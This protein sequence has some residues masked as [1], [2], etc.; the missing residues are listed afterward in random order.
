MKHNASL[1]ARAVLVVL[2]AALATV[3]ATAAPIFVVSLGKSVVLPE[4][5]KVAED[6]GDRGMAFDTPTG[7][8]IEIAVWKPQLDTGETLDAKHVAWEHL[9]LLRR[10]CNFIPEHEMKVD[11]PLAAHSLRVSGRAE[12]DGKT[13]GGAF[14]ASVLDGGRACVIG[15]FGEFASADA[16]A[17]HAFDLIDQLASAAAGVTAVPPSTLVT[18]RPGTTPESGGASLGT[19]TPAVGG[20]EGGPTPAVPTARPRERRAPG[21]PSSRILA[22]RSPKRS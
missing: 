12:I 6:A 13:W 14:M 4:G 20:G 9:I 18:G 16:G 1:R 3:S 22:L 19:E 7:E 2:A 21:S 15:C 17:T 8:R 10:S 5:W 11:S